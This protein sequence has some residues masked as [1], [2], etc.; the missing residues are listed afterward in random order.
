[1]LICTVI[2]Q[3]DIFGLER[4]V[5][6]TDGIKSV[7]M[8][9]KKAFSDNGNSDYYTINFKNTDNIRAI[10]LLSIT[11]A[12]IATVITVLSREM[13]TILSDWCTR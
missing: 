8:S 2:R 10:L 9:T 12:H 3:T 13:T 1:M 11:D 5:P 6:S 4:Y 7:E